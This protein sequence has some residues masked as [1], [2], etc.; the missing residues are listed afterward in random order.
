MIQKHTKLTTPM[1]RPKVE[2]LL[3]KKNIFENNRF[4]NVIGVLSDDRSKKDQMHE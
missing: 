4:G 2:A 1:E 3:M